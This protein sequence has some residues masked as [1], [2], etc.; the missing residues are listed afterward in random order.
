[1][2]LPH[3]SEG[4]LNQHVTLEERHPSMDL[5]PNQSSTW[6]PAEGRRSVYLDAKKAHLLTVFIENW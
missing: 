3:S 4:V 2:S 1:M 5:K 6:G